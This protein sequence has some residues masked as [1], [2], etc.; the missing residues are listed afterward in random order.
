MKLRVLP[1]AVGDLGAGRSFYSQHG[2]ELGEYFLDS[3]FADIDSL[4]VYAGVHK[5][6]W[7]YHRMLARRF[8]FAIYYKI[9]G[10]VCTVW[11]VLDCRQSPRRV[12]G[13]LQGCV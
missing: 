13:A 6:L 8:P 7:G 1:S 4:A 9:D 5:Q 12:R 2:E 10:D 3:L 11:R